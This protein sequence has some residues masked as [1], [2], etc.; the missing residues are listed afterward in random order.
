M[1][2]PKATAC[3]QCDSKFTARAFGLEC[4]KCA[5]SK[6]QKC[7]D[8]DRKTRDFFIGPGSVYEFVCKMCR[9]TNQDD[10][11]SR[12]PSPKHKASIN[13]K[14]CKS[15]PNC[16]SLGKE[17]SAL[18]DIIGSLSAKLDELTRSFA[19]NKMSSSTP[20]NVRLQT[21]EVIQ[22]KEDRSRNLIITGIEE[23][24]E[25]EPSKTVADIVGKLGLD[26]SGLHDIR[27]LGKPRVGGRPRPIR[28]TA[29]DCESRDRFVRAGHILK[30]IDNPAKILPDRTVEERDQVNDLYSEAK[31]RNSKAKGSKNGKIWAVIGKLK[32]RLKQ[33]DLSE[34]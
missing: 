3:H 6:C 21:L 22:D 32:P 34:S 16:D 31:S 9:D 28:A 23:P 10:S 14:R 1:N 33:I 20:T 15:C 4:S 12:L 2:E 7:G 25:E 29:I 13:Q 19:A 5:H 8:F 27:R 11:N 26:A 17:V 30:S 24:E 18:K